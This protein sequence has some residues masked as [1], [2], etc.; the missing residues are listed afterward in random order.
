MNGAHLSGR[1]GKQRLIRESQRGPGL[2]LP[3]MA[4]E[5]NNWDAQF[6]IIFFPLCTLVVC[7]SFLAHDS[8]FVEACPVHEIE[9]MIMTSG[10]HARNTD[11]Y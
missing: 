10:E 6:V 5:N 2:P 1:Q 9:N 7:A 3:P 4:I 8:T 11:N